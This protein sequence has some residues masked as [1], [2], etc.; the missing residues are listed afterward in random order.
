MHRN[1]CQMVLRYLPKGLWWDSILNVAAPSTTHSKAWRH[2]CADSL[3]SHPDGTVSVIF[4]SARKHCLLPAQTTF[5]VLINSQNHLKR[6]EIQAWWSLLK[7]LLV[8]LLLCLGTIGAAYKPTQCMTMEREKKLM[9]WT[10]RFWY[11]FNANAAWR[12]KLV[13]KHCRP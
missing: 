2:L 6:I 13:L 5:P 12:N 3:A 11:A 4:I 7:A 9:S 8:V 10:L 1:L